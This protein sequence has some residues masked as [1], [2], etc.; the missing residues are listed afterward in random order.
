MP[1]AAQKLLTEL[2][3]RLRR[4]LPPGV[5]AGRSRPALRLDPEAWIDVE[6]AAG[7]L[8]DARDALASGDAS[9]ASTIA[10]AGLELVAP[11]LLP[12]LE[13]PW[14]DEAR[15][16]LDELAG[17]L[18]EVVARAGL[19]AGGDGLRTGTAAARELVARELFR[20]S[21]YLLLMELHAAGGDVARAM[22]VYEDLRTLLRDELGTVPAPAVRA[23]SERL[24]RGAPAESADSPAGAAAALPAPP[25]ALFGRDEEIEELVRRVRSHEMRLLT[26]VG[27]G[28]VGKTRLALETARRLA[29]GF[30]DGARFV[31]L[32]GVPQAGDVAAAIAHELSVVPEPGEGW[33]VALKRRLAGMRLLLVVDNLEHLLTVAPLLTG[34]LA[35]APGLTVL[36]TSREPTGL[37]AEHVWPVHALPFPDDDVQNPCNAQRYAAVAMFVDRAKARLPA[38]ELDEAGLPHV[39]RICRRLAGLPLALELATA[40]LALLS[41]AELAAR[42]D[43]ALPILIGGARDAPDRQKTLR[44]TID[45]SFDLLTAPERVAFISFAVFP[46]GATVQAAEEVTSASL[47]TLGGLVSKSLLT[48]DGDRLAMLPTVREYALERLA[49]HRDA[50]AVNERLA[51]FCLAIARDVTPRLAHEGGDTWLEMLEIERPNLAAGLDWALRSSRTELALSLIAELGEFWLIAHRRDEALPWIDAALE[52]AGGSFPHLRATALLHRARLDGLRRDPGRF[53]AAV[54]AALELF[55]DSGDAAGAAACLRQLAWAEAWA[56]DAE[57][58]EAL[59]DDALRAA[60]AADASAVALARSSSALV[61]ADYEENARRTREV[62]RDL[63]R[64]GDFHE[65]ARVCSMTAYRAIAGRRYEDALE[66]LAEGLEAGRRLDSPQATFFI[67]GNEGIAKLFLDDVDGAEEAFAEGL[68]ICVTARCE[69]V[70]DEALLGLAA[71]WLRK[72]RPHDAAFLAGAAERHQIASRNADERVVWDRL[73]EEILRPARSRIGAR[74]WDKASRRGASLTVREAIDAALSRAPSRGPLRPTG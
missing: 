65:L 22:R 38:F 63:R 52:H 8:P 69:D 68:S 1:D 31:S 64:V 16:H 73:H 19:L 46:A 74:S 5:L 62:T 34:L 50:D 59:S 71:V 45:W 58:A 49:E 67:R 54:R 17:N 28:G 12:G 30:A 66:W 35:A 43:R 29:P 10:R 18:L 61:A 55:R 33:E 14:V 44:A 57:R 13:R 47:D 6:A 41:T 11:G 2:L 4:S 32:E 7:A 40:R 25:G 9:S 15:R 56:G 36:V 60:E 21:A 48:R 53:V 26:L 42:L 37:A 39:L 70:V 51:R 24:L 20:E 3:S 27:V 72:G 23:M